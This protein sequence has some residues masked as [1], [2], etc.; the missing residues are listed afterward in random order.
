M[1]ID[2]RSAESFAREFLKEI[3]FLVRSTI[4]TDEADRVRAVASVDVLKFGGSRLRGFFPGNGEKLVALANHR[5]LDTIRVFREIETETALDA[6]EVA[7]VGTDNFVIANAERGLAAVRTVRANSGHVFH[8]P[9]PR[10]VAIGAASQRA[11][12]AN[13]DAHAALFA[14]EVI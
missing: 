6:Q 4:R 9:G 3:V 12:R 7:V 1:M 14:F 2:V 8:F 10:F 11:D 5:L 13:V